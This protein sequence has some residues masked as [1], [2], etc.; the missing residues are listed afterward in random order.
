MDIF[1]GAIAPFTGFVGCGMVMYGAVEQKIGIIKVGAGLIAVP[2][3]A[4]V[5]IIARYYL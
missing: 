4:M 5:C 3:V 2:L 1:V